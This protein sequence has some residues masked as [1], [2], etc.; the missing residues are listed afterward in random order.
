GGSDVIY[1][2]SGDDFIHA[3]AGDDAVS[4]AEAQ[5]A[6]DNDLP[7]GADFYT[8]GG[9]TAA[10]PHNPP[11]YNPR[12][13]Q[14]AAYYPHHPL[15]KIP[16]FL[17]NFDTT[18]AAG[19]KIDDGTD[20]ILGDDGNDWLVGGTDNDRLFGGKGD[21]VLSADDNLDT[22]GGLNNQPDAPQFAD[23]DF[24]YGGVRLHVPIPHTD[25]RRH[26]RRSGQLTPPPAPLLP[27]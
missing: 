17:L 15:A 8:H 13:P 7:V 6:W 20:R 5:A 24:V 12:T 1:G 19:N 10:D 14:L 16:N 9:Y 27:L 3:G 25:R 11:R 26:V 21:D 2:G 18:D 22:N 23:R 4:G